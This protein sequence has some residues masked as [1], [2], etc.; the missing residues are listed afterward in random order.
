[1]W[2]RALVLLLAGPLLAQNGQEDQKPGWPCV[3]GRA[4]DPAYIE[5]SE[6]T[7]GQIFL[8]Q[9]GELEHAAPVMGAGYSH[10]ATVVRAVGEISGTRDFEVPVDSTIRSVLVLVSLQCRKAIH[11]Y[12][13]AG[14]EM[15]PANS[16]EF[17]DLQTGRIL[18]LDNPE[19]G[20]WRIR[21]AGA[22]LFVLA[23]MAKTE[24]VLSEVKL[25]PGA[26]GKQ[27]VQ[28]GVDGD[29]SEVSF[30]LASPGGEFMAKV[31]SADGVLSVKPAAERFRL[32]MTG[33]DAAGWE[34]RRVHPV[35]FRVEK[36]SSGA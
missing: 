28:A 19:P 27:T 21:L 20:T 1:M 10:P 30:H 32:V 13:P 22:G 34:V 2:K 33:R 6:S 12:R 7:G 17:T 26:G 31:E 15:T 25:L 23:V 29:V 4:V 35:L 36:P 11:V 18:R 16:T 14:D 5:I 3:A 8:F 9:K 24:I